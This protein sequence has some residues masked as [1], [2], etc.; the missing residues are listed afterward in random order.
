MI[1]FRAERFSRE[2]AEIFRRRRFSREARDFFNV[3]SSAKR[4]E[5]RSSAAF[6]GV[7]ARTSAARSAR[8][9]SISW[10]IPVMTGIFE[11]AISRVKLSSLKRARSSFEPPPRRIA[12][13][14]TS[15]FSLKKRSARIISSAA[16]RPW[17]PVFA[18]VSSIPRQRSFKILI[19]SL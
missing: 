8:E 13:A 4:S 17:T 1:R 2:R 5:V 9:T 6:E 16:P 12:I 10:P 15:D 18:T 14:S 3:E 7:E 19:K 11:R